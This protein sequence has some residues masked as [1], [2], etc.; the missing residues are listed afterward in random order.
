MR[1]SG[2]CWGWIIILHPRRPVYTCTFYILEKKMYRYKTIFSLL[3]IT[4]E[5]TVKILHWCYFFGWR[6]LKWKLFNSLS[7]RKEDEIHL[8]CTGVT[9][10][11]SETDSL[12]HQQGELNL[13]AFEDTVGFDK[14]PAFKM[15]RLFSCSCIKSILSVFLGIWSKRQR[16]AQRVCGSSNIQVGECRHT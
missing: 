2:I 5:L 16:W 8:H 1:Y 11:S 13:S 12:R 6:R 4:T 3:L 15:K 10:D 9:A 7:S 14:N